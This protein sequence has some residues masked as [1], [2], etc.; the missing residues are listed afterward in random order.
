[1][2]I[3]EIIGLHFKQGDD[4]FI[5]FLARWHSSRSKVSFFTEGDA[6]FVYLA[7]MGSHMRTSLDSI[8]SGMI[9][10]R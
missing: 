9:Q 4:Q 1:M 2:L 8:S 3:F 10:T 5:L 6:G 7:L